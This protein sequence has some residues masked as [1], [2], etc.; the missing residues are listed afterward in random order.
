M[1]TVVCYP[2]RSLVWG[3]IPPEF[4]V[5]AVDDDSTFYLQVIKYQP[6]LA[7]MFTEAFRQPV[8]DWVPALSLCLSDEIRKVIIPLHQDEAL[9]QEIVTR[10]QIPNTYVL[11]ASLSHDEIHQQLRLL[12]NLSTASVAKN[13]EV[14]ETAQQGR[15]FSLIGAG[16]PGITTFCINFPLLLARQYPHKRIAVI[17]MNIQKPDLSSF[18]QLSKHQLARFRPDLIDA[19]QAKKRDWLA[20]CKP[21]EFSENLFYANAAAAWRN[22]ELNMLLDVL[23]SHFDLVYLDW[24]NILPQREMM[25]L[26]LRESD[27]TMLFTRP[28]PFNLHLAAKLIEQYKNPAYSL[29]LI[30]SPFHKEEM[31]LRK[32]SET[33]GVSVS[34]FIPYV[35]EGRL[36]QSLQS[37]SIL[38][39]E[40][41]PPKTYT[42]GLKMFIREEQAWEGVPHSK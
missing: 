27:Q 1:K 25:H 3:F 10:K 41:F 28:D 23:R 13:M 38:V 42:N 30:V 19:R 17:D 12:T 34:Q 26:L 20:L 24:G 11:S 18:F 4:E 5:L 15:V 31:S 29:Q 21:S 32:I 22:Y 16:S 39:Q 33:V 9:V 6:K 7:V 14:R 35:E 2:M 40:L 36:I 8:W 37:R